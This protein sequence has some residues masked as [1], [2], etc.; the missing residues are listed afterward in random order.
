ML[1]SNRQ[2][3]TRLARGNQDRGISWWLVLQRDYDSAKMRAHSEGN[4]KQFKNPVQLG[5]RFAWDS[6]IV[7]EDGYRMQT[8]LVKADADVR[9][10]FQVTSCHD[11]LREIGPLA[12][13]KRR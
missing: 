9:Y 6:E 3:P 10:L 13:T 4:L 2:I 1:P 11:P 5:F 7:Q 8:L 12:R